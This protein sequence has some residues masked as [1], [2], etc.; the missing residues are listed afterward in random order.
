MPQGGH[1]VWSTRDFE[2]H[3]CEQTK[4]IDSCV[5]TAFPL[6]YSTEHSKWL[7]PGYIF[8]VVL[9]TICDVMATAV[10]ST[11]V[12]L[13][14]QEAIQSDLGHYRDLGQLHKA[15]IPSDTFP[16]CTVKQCMLYVLC[17]V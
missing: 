7:P 8:T 12:P 6:I 9:Q 2:W 5:K 15:G 3:C 4:H 16:E 14:Q 11:S 17:A 13:L 1:Q 10:S